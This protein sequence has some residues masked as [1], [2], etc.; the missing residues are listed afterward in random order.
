MQDKGIHCNGFL[1]RIQNNKICCYIAAFVFSCIFLALRGMGG[2]EMRL[3]PD[4][5]GCMAVPATLGGVD[6]PEIIPLS[7]Y[8]GFAYYFIFAPLFKFCHNPQVIWM[9]IV[10]A[11]NLLL[12]FASV[13]ADNTCSR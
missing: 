13:L 8:K 6:W 4:D 10:I 12:A 3:F 11:N 9:V 1:Y 2:Y 5:I 7:L